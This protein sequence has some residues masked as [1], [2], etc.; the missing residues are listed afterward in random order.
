MRLWS[1]FFYRNN[2]DRR[3]GLSVERPNSCWRWTEATKEFV[4]LESILGEDDLRDRYRLPHCRSLD[5]EDGGDD[6]G[7]EGDL[8]RLVRVEKE[9]PCC[10]RRRCLERR[11]KRRRGRRRD[12]EA[13]NF[14]RRRRWRDVEI[15]RPN[16]TPSRKCEG[17]LTPDFR[18]TVFFR[19][20][21][22]SL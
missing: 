7:D 1:I 8:R 16:S 9:L 4:D 12:C 21:N 11:R 6:G 22:A 14:P 18:S 20:F 5:G 10:W 15:R 19:D 13:R 3:T 2:P 17:N